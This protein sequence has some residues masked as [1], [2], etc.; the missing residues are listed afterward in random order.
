MAP[1]SKELAYIVLLHDSHLDASGKTTDQKLEAKH[2]K[3]A[4]EV[5]E[6]MHVNIHCNIYFFVI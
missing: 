4:A 1:L 3:K 2:F 5:F 6:E